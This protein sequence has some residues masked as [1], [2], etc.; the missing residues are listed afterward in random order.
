MARA[1][2]ISP[3]TLRKIETGRLSTP[4]FGTVVALGR[5]LDLP[6]EE[7]ARVWE[8]AETESRSA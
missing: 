1:A 7:L 4:S 2:G 8:P 5:V 3:E 6:L